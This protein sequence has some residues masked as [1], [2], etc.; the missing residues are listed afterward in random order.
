VDQSDIL[1]PRFLN[2]GLNAWRRK[3]TRIAFGHEEFS[4]WTPTK[5]QRQPDA[6]EEKGIPDLAFGLR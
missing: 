1:S 6:L 4:A 3:P 5:L 2:E